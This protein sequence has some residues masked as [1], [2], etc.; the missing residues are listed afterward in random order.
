[1]GGCFSCRLFPSGSFLLCKHEAARHSTAC[2]TIILAHKHINT[3]SEYQSF[4]GFL[5]MR[6]QKQIYAAANLLHALTCKGV[7]T[8][9]QMREEQLFPPT[10]C[11][12]QLRDV[13]RKSPNMDSKDT[14][15][16]ETCLG[17]TPIGQQL[18]ARLVCGV[19][20]VSFFFVNSKLTLDLCPRLRGELMDGMSGRPLGQT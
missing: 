18:V 19:Q 16:Q 5:Y 10:P 3:R 14:K 4:R 20:H 11:S 6:T 2:R 7:N 17:A 13:T 8:W 15:Q 1:M 9:R 12:S